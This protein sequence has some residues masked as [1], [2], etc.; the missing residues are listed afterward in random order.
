MKERSW[1]SGLTVLALLVICVLGCSRSNAD[2]P[3]TDSSSNHSTASPETA[4]STETAAT[5]EDISGSYNVTG[6]NEDGSPYRGTLDVIKRGDVF[7]FKWNAG[8]QYDGVG[9]P[10]GNVV[11]VAFTEGSDGKGCGVVS[12]RILGD[13]TLDGKWGY[14]GVNESGTEKATRTNGSDLVGVY[15]TVGQNP[16]GKQYKGSL[17]VGTKGSGYTFSWSNQTLGFGIRR[18]NNVSVGLG[19]PQCAFVAYEVRPNGVLDGVW[20]GYGSDKTG[21]EKATKK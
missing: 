11:A 14:W 13:G 8:K 19:G 15:D 2:A 7:Q 3:K 20:G 1:L 5:T 17:S 10:N 21:T 18:A 4:S 12:Y 16:D 6:T 9:V